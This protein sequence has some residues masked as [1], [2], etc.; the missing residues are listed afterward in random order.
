MEEQFYLIWPFTFVRFKS[1]RL[2]Y[3]LTGLILIMPI[4]RVVSFLFI[5]SSRE[6]IG[7]MLHTGGDA[8]MIGC[9]TAMIEKSLIFQKKYS[10]MLAHTYLVTI[11]AV[12]LFLI[13]PLCTF[14]F[15]AAYNLTI[16]M[17]LN[18]ISI[19]ILLYWCMYTPSRI[20]DFL[21]KRLISNL[22]VASY[23]LYVWQQLFVTGKNDFWINKFP[24][25]ILVAVSVGLTSHYLIEKPVLNLKNRFKKV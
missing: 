15:Q 17:T 19:M 6:Y 25:N 5:P 8:I 14:F 18:S 12:F 24:Q 11:V 23:S 16:G 13:S 21:N 20:S 4:L 1:Q 10:I 9:L 3:G 22:G 7:G 2:I